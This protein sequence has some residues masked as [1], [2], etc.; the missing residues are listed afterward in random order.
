MSGHSVL[1][2]FEDSLDSY[3]GIPLCTKNDVVLMSNCGNEITLWVSQKYDSSKIA[4]WLSTDKRI[5]DPERISI[6]KTR[7][8]NSTLWILQFLRIPIQ[9]PKYDYFYCVLFPGI[10]ITSRTTRIVRV[11]D[12]YSNSSKR[13]ETFFESPAKLK[14]RIAKVLRLDAL[15]GVIPNSIL[16]F[17][18]NWTKSRFLQTV[19]KKPK[20]YCVINNLVQFPSAT[21]LVEL[22]ALPQRSVPLFVM[23]GGQR[24]R[25][26]PRT[27]INIWADNPVSNSTQLTIVGKCPINLLNGHARKHLASGNLNFFENLSPEE[28]QV[29]ISTS[30]GTIFY[31]HGEGWGQPIAE[32]LA[33]GKPIICNDLPVFREVA[34]RW[35]FYFPTH[36]PERVIPL[37]ELVCR[38]TGHRAS[39][40]SEI[41]KYAE[42][43][44]SKYLATE[45]SKI[46][47]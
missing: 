12:P 2:D 47:K 7:P 3:T 25:K 41:L 1:V 26:D 34:G 23:I 22:N 24:Q 13:L 32:S 35:G 19:Y 30:V 27:I 6:L 28:L 36:E 38:T 17:N 33:C 8:R 37:I 4:E 44:K 31:S 39:S 16:V 46:L 29:L 10:R 21:S 14:L 9:T 5:S 20:D 40:T 18:S 45:W 11:H 43:Y 42:K 15:L